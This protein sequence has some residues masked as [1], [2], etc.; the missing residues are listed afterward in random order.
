MPLAIS[1]HETFEIWFF[2]GKNKKK[3]F[4]IWIKLRCSIKKYSYRIMN[5]CHLANFI[6]LPT[7]QT[8][9]LKSK[10]WKFLSQLINQILCKDKKIKYKKLEDLWSWIK[11]SFISIFL[12]SFW[13]AFHP[14]NFLSLTGIWWT[15]LKENRKMVLFNEY[16]ISSGSKKYF[17]IPQI[18]SS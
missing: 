7:I 2:G 4:N 16:N 9:L 12:S 18:Y 8:I 1:I 10:L 3:S 6:F 5:D 17:I 15:V 14:W 11:R 13:A